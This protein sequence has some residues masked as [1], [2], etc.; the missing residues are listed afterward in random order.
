MQKVKFRSKKRTNLK[1]IFLGVCLTIILHLILSLPGAAIMNTLK[2]PLAAV[3]IVGIITHL[4]CGI[5][6]AF[7]LCKYKH[8]GAIISCLISSLLFFAISVPVGIFSGDG[9]VP[10]RSVI[11]SGFYVVECTVGAAIFKLLSNK[12]R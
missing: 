7:V 1:A 8:D 12:K 9:G 3:G 10:L 2:N 4:I 5:I 11:N 6:T